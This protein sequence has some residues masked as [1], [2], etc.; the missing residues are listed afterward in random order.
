MPRAH[1]EVWYMTFYRPDNSHRLSLCG[2]CPV[3]G[4]HPVCGCSTQLLAK[5]IVDPALRAFAVT[6]LD[7]DL[8]TGGWAWRINIDAIQRSM[9]TLAQFDSG[10]RHKEEI[11]GRLIG[12]TEDRGDGD[13]VDELEPYKGDV[14]MVWTRTGCRLRWWW[15]LRRLAPW[16]L[17]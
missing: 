2:A 7:K 10:K 17:S 11:T 14:S 1:G 4:A 3:C 15:L 16:L 8:A 13:D 9:G 6:N 5:D 12:G